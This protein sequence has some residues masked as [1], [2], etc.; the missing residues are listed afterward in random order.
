[1]MT[2]TAVVCGFALI[3]AGSVGAQETR[4][5]GPGPYAAGI[6]EMLHRASEGHSPTAEEIAAAGAIA[7]TPDD[8]A[9]K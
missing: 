6:T 8:A 7:I 9:V 2:R 5:P 3:C 1:M 4:V